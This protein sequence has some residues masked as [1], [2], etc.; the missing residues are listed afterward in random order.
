MVCVDVDVVVVVIVK[1]WGR[2]IYEE[3]VNRVEN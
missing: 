3:D 1:G 2:Y